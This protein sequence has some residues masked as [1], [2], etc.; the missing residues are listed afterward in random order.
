M[1]KLKNYLG[2]CE[3]RCAEYMSAYSLCDVN[4][5]E[6]KAAATEYFNRGGKRLRPAFLSLCAGALG[7]KEREMAVTPAMVS[8]ELFHTFTLVHDDIIDNDETRRGGKSAHVLVRDMFEKNSG[9]SEYGKDIAILAG[10]TLH[11]LSVKMLLECAS[12]PLFSAETVLGVAK[13]LE[14]EC[15]NELLSGE[16]VDT[17]LGVIK[18]DTFSVGNTET[19]LE[20]MRQK[21]G[22]LFSYAARAGAMLGLDTIDTENEKVKALGEFAELSGIAF[23]IKDDILGIISDEKTLGKPIGSDI[24]E[25][26]KTVILQEAYKNADEGEKAFLERVVGNSNAS[27]NDIERV[28]LIFRERGGLDKAEKLA[29]SYIE[30]SK[31]A[32]EK[33]D[34]S[35]YRDMLLL[36][37][38]FMTS[39]KK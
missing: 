7:G 14:G 13:I 5:P 27:A 4:P 34:D 18:N 10:D 24:R 3:K 15:I 17:R 33:I 16:A 21:T 25:G 29:D 35:E 26:K 9:A 37:S 31:L 20:V 28:K 22:V 2:A 1:E 39:R 30:K 6:L 11:A 38:D 36:V 32:L 19:T 8:V 23:Q 12:S